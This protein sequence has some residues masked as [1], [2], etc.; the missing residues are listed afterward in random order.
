VR[1]LREIGAGIV[2]TPNATRLLYR[3]GLGE[4]LRG[5]A[6]APA[7]VHQRRWQ[8]GRTLLLNPLAQHVGHSGE[9]L[10]LTAHRADVLSMLQAAVPPERLHL[11]C[12]LSAITQDSTNVTLSFDSGVTASADIAIGADG[13]R[14]TVRGTM[15]G[16]EEPRFTGCVAY[17]GMVA[18]DRFPRS[19]THSEYGFWL[20]PGSHFVHYPV[21]RG[22]LINFISLIDR[23]AW[24]E[25]SWTQP[26][27]PAELRAFY[28]GWHEQVRSLVAT[29]E[30]TFVWGLFDREPLSRWS[31]DRIT[32]LGDAAHPMLPF[33]AQGA[34]QAIEDGAALAECI[35]VYGASP[36]ALAHYEAVRLPRTARIQ[37][38]ARGNKTRNHLP[39][40]PEQQARDAQ[41]AAGGAQWAI[42]VSA[43]VYDHDAANI[44]SANKGLPSGG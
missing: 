21:R 41:M 36:A 4:A 2:L 19:E 18:A 39:D 22:E 23:E 24:T 6:V 32:L 13:I 30:E 28:A 17:R 11:N 12:R 44:D 43:W 29:V 37:T 9:S 33:M 25:E 16:V 3:A 34:A 26:A 38:V 27:D 40:G 7:A 8:D 5:H 1:T 31:V 14:S 42:G 10:F 15:F 35:K 20:G